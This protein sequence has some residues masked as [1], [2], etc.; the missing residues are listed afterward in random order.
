MEA[1]DTLRAVCGGSLRERSTVQELP[2]QAKVH[3]SQ[4][5]WSMYV[6]LVE[7]LGTFEEAREVYDKMIDAKVAS[8]QVRQAPAVS[9]QCMAN[10]QKH[11]RNQQENR[12][13]ISYVQVD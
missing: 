3:R 7:A 4:R 8:V 13:N 9:S 6:D 5:V 11:G 10:L 12:C 1:R 2:P